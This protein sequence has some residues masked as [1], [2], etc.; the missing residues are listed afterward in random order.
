MQATRHS[1]YTLRRQEQTD[2]RIIVTHL[3]ARGARGLLWWH[4]PSGMVAGG[5]RN[6]NGVPI[7]AAIMKGLGWRAGISDFLALHLGRFYALE[8]KPLKGGRATAAQLEFLDDVRTAGGF[9][10]LCHGI[11]AALRTLETWGLLRGRAS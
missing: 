9:A 7:N 4:T 11:D 10:A 1:G 3:R 2:H 6:A 8:L 5:K